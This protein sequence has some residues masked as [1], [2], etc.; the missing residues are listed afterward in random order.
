MV[1]RSAPRTKAYAPRPRT[2][3]VRTG[4]LV[5]H[6]KNGRSAE[7]AQPRPAAVVAP[8]QR[9]A[10]VAPVPDLRGDDQQHHRN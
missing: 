4:R 6:A 3:P 8:Q 10:G 1:V 5:R 7:P 9:C 2:Q